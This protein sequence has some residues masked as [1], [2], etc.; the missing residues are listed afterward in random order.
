MQIGS[1]LGWGD[2]WIRFVNSSLRYLWAISIQYV[3]LLQND[4]YEQ[5]T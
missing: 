4:H 5:V 1:V 3:L 2:R